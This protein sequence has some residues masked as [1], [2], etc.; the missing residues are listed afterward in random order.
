MENKPRFDLNESIADWRAGLLGSPAFRREDVDELE[1]HLRDTCTDLQNKAL[2]EEE[3]FLV[4]IRRL[5]HGG[6]LEQEF[7]KVHNM[8]GQCVL[9]MTI[10]ALI[11]TAMIMPIT[12]AAGCLGLLFGTMV[13]SNATVLFCL[14]LGAGLC[15]LAV[16]TYLAFLFFTRRYHH[17]AYWLQRPVWAAMILF[18]LALGMRAVGMMSSMLLARL[19]NPPVLAMSGYLSFGYTVVLPL[20]LFVI[21]LVLFSV[22]QVRH[23]S[24]S[25]EVRQGRGSG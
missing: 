7:S 10:G 25:L 15:S 8:A 23:Q 14:A 18:V 5:G 9:W 2:S 13:S 19:V 1:L 21:V 24:W 12:N 11:F 4:A 3:S 20:V 22:R 16:L 17:V 6:K